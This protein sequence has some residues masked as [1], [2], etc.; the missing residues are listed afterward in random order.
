MNNLLKQ[1]KPVAIALDHLQSE[2][3]SMADVFDMWF[4]LI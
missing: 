3:V 1:L 2:K 4:D